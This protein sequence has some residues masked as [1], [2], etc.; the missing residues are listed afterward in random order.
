[1]AVIDS[2]DVVPKAMLLTSCFQK[3]VLNFILSALKQ[4]FSWRSTLC[5]KN[6]V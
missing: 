6:R 3:H 4:K 5:F 1:M 2:V